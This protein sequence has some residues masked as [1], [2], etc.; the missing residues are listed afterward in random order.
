MSKITEN[1]EN[2]KKDSNRKDFEEDKECSFGSVITFQ[3]PI[4]K[5]YYHIYDDRKTSEGICITFYNHIAIR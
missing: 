3:A 4:E 2:E 1:S 5:A